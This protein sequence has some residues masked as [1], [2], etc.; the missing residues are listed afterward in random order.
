MTPAEFQAIAAR[1]SAVEDRL[2]LVGRHIDRYA[3]APT[4]QEELKE[5]IDRAVALVV[6]AHAAAQLFIDHPERAEDLV[7]EAA[8][9]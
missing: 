6:A 1:L 9:Q 5:H 3:T 4:A 2:L 7:G 8:G